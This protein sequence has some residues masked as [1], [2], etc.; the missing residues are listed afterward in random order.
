M[1]DSD[2]PRQNRSTWPPCDRPRIPCQ[3]FFPGYARHLRCLLSPLDGRREGELSEANQSLISKDMSKSKTRLVRL[4]V[5][6]SLSKSEFN[7][8][9]EG[10]TVLLVSHSDLNTIIITIPY[11]YTCTIS[12]DI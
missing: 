5:R 6:G 1:V 3:S 8:D 7:M 2:V 9:L 10:L 12:M 11:K 4:Q